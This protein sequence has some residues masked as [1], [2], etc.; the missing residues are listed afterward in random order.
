METSIQDLMDVRTIEP[1]YRHAQIFEKFDEL[2]SGEHFMLVNDHDPKPLYY[3]ILAERGN[4]FDWQYVESGPE[5]WQILIKKREKNNTET[6][7]E[8][9]AKDIRKAQV[10]K[11]YGID[12]CC[13]GKKSLVQACE[14]KGIDI[15]VLER[16]LIESN[17]QKPALNFDSFSL[18]FLCDYILNTHHQYVK[19]TLPM[20]SELSTK[21]FTKHGEKFPELKKIDFLVQS[22]N[23][24]MTLHM[25]KEEMVLFPFIKRLTSGAIPKLD[26]FSLREPITMMEMEHE[27][28]GALFKEIAIFSND[29]TAPE[30]ACNSF[31]L[32][33]ASLKEFYDDLLT[34]IHLENNILFPKSL[35]LVSNL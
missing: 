3:Q 11:S 28:V 32:L 5:V 12:F 16:E 2:A 31:K 25:H 10:F 1:K 20:I 21:V 18:E 34:H 30:N 33:Y 24:E 8:I 29:Y 35:N 13:G 22:V 26:S 27:S 9:A 4:I 17:A 6:V 15:N 19:E 23:Q 14:E 7:G